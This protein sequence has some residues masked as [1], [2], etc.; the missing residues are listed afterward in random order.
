MSI[1]H[2]HWWSLSILCI[3]F[4][5]RVPALRRRFLGEGIQT[6]LRCFLFFPVKAPEDSVG[7]NGTP[8]EG[9][10]F[11]V[12][13]Q[14]GPNPPRPRLA[15]GCRSTSEAWVVALTPDTLRFPQGLN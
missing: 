5:Y 10:F 6:S 14:I 2:L 8:P 12:F 1:K 7:Y 4:I 15:Q 13:G 9:P 3:F 11:P